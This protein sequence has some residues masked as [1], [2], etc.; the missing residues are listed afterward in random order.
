MKETL[1][2]THVLLKAARLSAIDILDDT[3]KPFK[4]AITVYFE[5]ITQLKRASEVEPYLSKFYRDKL[6]EA[7]RE[8]RALV[9][10]E[11]N[12]KRQNC[13]GVARGID[14]YIAMLERI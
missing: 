9:R 1:A 7:R 11:Q 5:A 2:N 13:D 6:D 3:S 10:I 12:R 8:A 14:R 4:T